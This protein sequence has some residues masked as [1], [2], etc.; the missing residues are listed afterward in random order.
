[1]QHDHIEGIL[2]KVGCRYPKKNEGRCSI[3]KWSNS[4]T[5]GVDAHKNEDRCSNVVRKWFSTVLKWQ[6][7][8]TMTM[9]AMTARMCI[10]FGVKIVALPQSILLHQEKKEITSI[11]NIGINDRVYKRK[12]FKGI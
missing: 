11:K 3:L 6:K 4:T 10:H 2:E 8:Y 12:T 1:M 9:P 7:I 5:L